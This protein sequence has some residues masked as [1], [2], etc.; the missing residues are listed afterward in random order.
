MRRCFSCLMIILMPMTSSAADTQ[1]AM[2]TE[3]QALADEFVASLKPQLKKALQTQ[4]PAGAI[5][6]CAD[7]APQ[8]ADSLTYTSG[9]NVKRVSL[10]AR[11]ASRAIPDVWEKKHLQ[12]FDSVAANL[13]ANEALEYGEVVGNRF[14]YLRAQIAEP[15]C[16]ICHGRELSAE[17]AQAIKSYY[18]DDTA[19]GYDIGNVRG[20]ISLSRRI[21]SPE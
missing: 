16:L 2:L 20:A 19:I 3:A 15:V 5:A 18:P 4:G 17:V 8:L 21:D 14:R 12:Q 6:V 1:Q 11:N 10:R 9:W 13:N 7:V